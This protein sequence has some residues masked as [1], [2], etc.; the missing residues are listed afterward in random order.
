MNIKN[1][2]GC[3]TSEMLTALKEGSSTGFELSRTKTIDGMITYTLVRDNK[4]FLLKRKKYKKVPSF[5][6]YQYV[7]D[8]EKN[9]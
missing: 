1:L 3:I 2:N 6:A 7:G 5:P 8:G 4:D 9:R